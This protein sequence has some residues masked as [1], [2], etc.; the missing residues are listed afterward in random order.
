MHV[1][2][3]A[4]GTGEKDNVYIYNLDFNGCLSRDPLLLC[5]SARHRAFDPTALGDRLP[6]STALFPG[7]PVV[8]LLSCTSNA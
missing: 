7:M 8:I 3:D 2:V 5:L 4:G 1:R 6:F